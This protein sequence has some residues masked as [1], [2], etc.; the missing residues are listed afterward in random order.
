[1][2]RVE[3][4]VVGPVSTNCYF[5]INDELKEGVIVDPGEGAGQIQD[6]FTKEKVTPVAILLTHGHFDHIFLNFILFLNFTVLC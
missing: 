2:I 1:M 4:Q 5:L 6:F 3:F